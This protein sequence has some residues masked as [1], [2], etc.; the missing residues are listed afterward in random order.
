MFRIP[1]IID[2]ILNLTENEAGELMEKINLDFFDRHKDIRRVLER[3]F[4]QVSD[5]LPH[6]EPLS[7]T[8]KLLIG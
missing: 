7:E 2:R 5:Y 3:H 6:T 4:D 1:K 8:K